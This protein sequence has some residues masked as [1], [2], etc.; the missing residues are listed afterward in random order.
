MTTVLPEGL[1]PWGMQDTKSLTLRTLSKPIIK[2]LTI[3]GSKSETNRALVIAAVSNGVSKLHGALFSDDTY[4]CLDAL[5]KLGII[6]NHDRE[7]QLI[8]VAGEKFLR[9]RGDSGSVYIGSAGTCARF[10]PGLIAARGAGHIV[11]E[12]SQ[13]LAN[14]PIQELTDALKGLGAVVGSSEGDKSFPMAIEGETLKGGEVSVSGSL[15]SQF[16]SGLL[17][18][19]P[20]AEQPVVV[21]VKDTIVQEN[22]V[23]ITLSIMKKFGVS[24]GY[25][26]D[27]TKF[28]IE[29][30]SYTATDVMI[31]ADASTATYFLALAAITHSQITINNLDTTTQ[32]P[33]IEFLS[34]L[35]KLGCDVSTSNESVTVTGPKELQGNKVFDLAECS[36]CAAALVAIAPYA[37]GPI[38][39][40]GIGHI[41]SHECDRISVMCETLNN[42]GIP[43]IEYPDGL[44]IEPTEAKPRFFE[45]DPHDD[46]RMAMGFSIMG[47][48]GGGVKIRRPAC[49][50]KTCPDFY[51]R[52]NSLGI[53]VSKDT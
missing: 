4:W 15:S 37:N 46:H 43:V 30:Q 9:P 32:Q 13:Q 33:D 10:L 36:D 17:I 42:A 26:P 23:R 16:L 52:L 28:T 3:P 51:D 27:L 41:R 21:N 8:T 29:P 50:S 7:K 24:V 18:A 22:Y 6:F 44:K 35:K 39:I 53:R 47:A 2:S 5:S 14:R 38:E 19:S 45:V 12:S 11:L 49:V 34:I 48:G 20:L 40:R 1:S 31:E 25:P